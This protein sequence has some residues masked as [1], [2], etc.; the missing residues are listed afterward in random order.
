MAGMTLEERVADLEA[1]VASLKRQAADK[2]QD[3]RPWWEQRRGALKD[4]PHYVEAMRLSRE[5]REAQRAEYE[6]EIEAA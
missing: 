4:D 5:W 2:L 6:G 1:E 3:D